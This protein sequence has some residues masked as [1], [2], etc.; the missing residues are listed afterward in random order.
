MDLNKILK[1]VIIFVLL[2]VAGSVSYYYVIIL[3][4]SANREFQTQREEKCIELTNNE[5][6]R[7][8]AE[9]EIG[10]YLIEFKYKYDKKSNSCFIYFRQLDNCSVS[11]VD[12]RTY[13]TIRN[14]FTGETV[15]EFSYRAS[16]FSYPD[17]I[18]RFNEF[19][20]KIEQI[21]GK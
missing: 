20:K 7:Q 3:P 15:D 19:N 18:V 17:A 11:R 10:E 9:G 21:F 13:E 14:L 4:R 8:E 6:S 1:L 2:I 5:R 12:C 16:D